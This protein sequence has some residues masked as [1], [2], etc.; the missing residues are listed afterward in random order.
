MFRKPLSY[1]REFILEVLG[2]GGAS[3]WFLLLV[4]LTLGIAAGSMFPWVLV[5]P[6][7]IFT[8]A[9]IHFLAKKLYPNSRIIKYIDHGLKII[10]QGL[11]AGG[12]TTWFLAL[13]A[14]SSAVI[15]YVA[16]PVFAL[17]LLYYG[18]R[19]YREL[20]YGADDMSRL[21]WTFSFVLTVLGAGGASYWSLWFGFATLAKVGVVAAAATVSTVCFVVPIVIAA[22]AL[23]YY[24]YNHLGK[25]THRNSIENALAPDQNERETTEHTREPNNQYLKVYKDL[26]TNAYNTKLSSYP[27][28]D[29]EYYSLRNQSLRMFEGY[30]SKAKVSSERST[31]ISDTIKGIIDNKK[32]G[33]EGR[34][35]LINKIKEL[36]STSTNSHQGKATFRWFNEKLPITITESR[37]AR[38]CDRLLQSQFQSAASSGK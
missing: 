36:K 20:K 30:L 15:P 31:N 1:S 29:R 10:T 14:V 37:L 32:V 3:N 23:T 5:I 16:V 34:D 13:L 11:G 2:A 27:L 17:A 28:E 8:L 12:A 4:L 6:G 21:H 35:F 25:I 19:L 22:L 9:A 18:Y 26:M 33:T 38:E 7:A 24:L